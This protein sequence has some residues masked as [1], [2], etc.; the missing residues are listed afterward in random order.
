[1]HYGND[2]SNSYIVPDFNDQ[3]RKELE[4]ITEEKDFCFLKK[5]KNL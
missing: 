4:F 2:I 1:M 3:K 5:K